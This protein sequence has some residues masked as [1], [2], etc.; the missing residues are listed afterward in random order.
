L[1]IASVLS[2]EIL[3]ISKK[4]TLERRPRSLILLKEGLVAVILL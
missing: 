2:K 3:K 1:R 4:Y